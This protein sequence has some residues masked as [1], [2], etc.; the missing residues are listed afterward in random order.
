MVFFLLSNI[1]IRNYAAYRVEKNVVFN[2]GGASEAK[3]CFLSLA[4]DSI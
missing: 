4:D 1:L 3:Q 2:S